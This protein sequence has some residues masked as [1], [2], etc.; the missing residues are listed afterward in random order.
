MSPSSRYRCLRMFALGVAIGL[1]FVAGV[2]IFV[3]GFQ[4]AGG[5]S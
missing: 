1:L 3:L 4:A 2:A 5:G